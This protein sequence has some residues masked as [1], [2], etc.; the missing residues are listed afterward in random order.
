MLMERTAPSAIAINGKIY[1]MGG[2][3]GPDVILAGMEEY[4]PATDT[5]TKKAD[6]PT[7]R[8]APIL[9]AVNGKIYAM[10]GG[11]FKKKS[12]FDKRNAPLSAV[13]V[14]DPVTDTWSKK[15]DMPIAHDNRAFGFLDGKLYLFGTAREA[16][17]IWHQDYAASRA[18][19]SYD[20][21]T[22]TL[23]RETDMPSA[24]GESSANVINDRIYVV[25]GVAGWA[26]YI[27]GAATLTK[28]EVFTPGCP[29]PSPKDKPSQPG[30]MLNAEPGSGFINNE[31][32]SLVSKDSK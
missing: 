31:D 32:N 9:T 13:E 8:Y 27:K 15:D 19:Y 6:M 16:V 3:D 24:R 7:A 18:V 5:W 10:G 2:V 29:L 14:Y 17:R 28:M 22:G 26:G 11:F 30:E 4:D 1:A 12:D 25:G 23:T 21:K 20:L